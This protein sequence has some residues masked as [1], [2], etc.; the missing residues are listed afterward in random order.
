MLTSRLV[1]ELSFLKNVFFFVSNELV[2]NCT[3]TMNVSSDA[4]PLFR[5]ASS[6]TNITDVDAFVDDSSKGGRTV[7]GRAHRQLVGSGERVSSPTPDRRGSNELGSSV[8]SPKS[9]ARVRC[10]SAVSGVVRGIAT[11]LVLKLERTVDSFCFG[12]RC[13]VQT[14]RDGLERIVASKTAC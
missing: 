4:I 7:S 14:S 13:V 1:E 8:A 6:P 9:S 3:I 2:S 11:F 5:S 12:F 10:A